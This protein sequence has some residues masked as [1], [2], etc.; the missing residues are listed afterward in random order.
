M[1]ANNTLLVVIAVLVIYYL[2]VTGVFCKDASSSSDDS[3]TTQTF[4]KFP[5]D[6]QKASGSSE[7][8]THARIA[9]QQKNPEGHHMA[10]T[11][12]HFSVCRDPNEI[13][14]T[15][16]CVCGDE[17]TYSYSEN[18]YGAPGVDYKMF[19][20]SQ[21]VDDQV[22][23]N[24]KDFVV[25]NHGQFATGRTWSPDSHDSYDPIPWVGLRRPEYVP[26]CNPTQVPDVD[27]NIYKGNRQFCFKT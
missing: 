14:K 23:K 13:D 1:L 6:K 2:I 19:V 25:A 27:T 8:A 18:D 24:H 12:E 5:E 3:D 7:S 9:D 20:T 21:A 22:V 26:V 17:T 15:L 16:D 11:L 4:K 10:E